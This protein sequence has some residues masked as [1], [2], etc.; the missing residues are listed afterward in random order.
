MLGGL[1]RR[2]AARSGMS[3]SRTREK[4]HDR[5]LGAECKHELDRYIESC[6]TKPLRYQALPGSA[7]FEGLQYLLRTNDKPHD[8]VK[9]LSVKH[10]QWSSCYCQTPLHIVQCALA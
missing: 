8:G 2:M 1:G 3:Y 5:D 6:D 4:S 9:F 10:L 7:L